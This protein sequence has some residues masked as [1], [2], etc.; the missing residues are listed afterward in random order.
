MTSLPAF[1]RMMFQSPLVG[2]ASFVLS[3]PFLAPLALTLYVAGMPEVAPVLAGANAAVDGWLLWLAEALGA[4]QIETPSWVA[5]VSWLTLVPGLII[6]GYAAQ[7]LAMRL[8]GTALR[9]RSTRQ[10]LRN[11]G[12][13]TLIFGLLQGVVFLLILAG[14]V[15]TAVSV[16]EISRFF[17][18]H[19]LPAMPVLMAAEYTEFGRAFWSEYQFVPM[20]AVGAMGL[21]FVFGGRYMAL[22]AAFLEGNLLSGLGAGVAS[23]FCS[24]IFGYLLYAMLAGGFWGYNLAAAEFGLPVL[25]MTIGGVLLLHL[26]LFWNWMSAAAAF[27]A[28]REVDRCLEDMANGIHDDALVVKGAM[29]DVPL[30]AEN[31]VLARQLKD[32]EARNAA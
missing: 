5:P 14:I 19:R 31:D 30:D 18:I 23:G 11:F 9:P 3:V 32:W 16:T 17:G 28:R 13:W 2:T 26:A 21:F 20:L 24:A 4:K 7:R 12:E 15:A 22:T 27:G 25:S 1:A 6:Y 8:A 10:F 29:R